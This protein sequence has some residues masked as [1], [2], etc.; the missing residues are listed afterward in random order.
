MG[1]VIVSGAS[2]FIGRHLV[3][4][5][6]EQGVSVCALAS[7]GRGGRVEKLPNVSVVECSLDDWS[8]AAARLPQNP[9]A[10]LCLAWGGVSPENRNSFECQFANVGL[11]LNAVRLAAAVHAQRFI[12]PGSTAEYAESQ[13]PINAQSAP[14]PQNAY[15]AAKI[16]ARFLCRALAEELGLPYIYTVITGTYSADRKDSNVIYYAISSLLQGKRPSFTR[17][18]QLWDYVHI[19]DV[20]RALHLIAAEGKGGAFYTIG[21]GD[22]WPLSNYILCIRDIINPDAELGLGDIPYKG[23]KM[24]SSCVDLRSLQED[25]GF[26]PRIPFDVGIREVI[27]EVSKELNNGQS[28]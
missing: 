18:E 3:R 19:D 2:G 28:I 16:A 5:L 26:V 20:V 24:P 22:N 9:D 12:L 10:F 8:E 14:S 6:S 15:G 21:H 17:L 1:T 25:T 23:G 11:S 4:Y 13:G 7:P 27:A